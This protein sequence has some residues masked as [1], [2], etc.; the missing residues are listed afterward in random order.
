MVLQSSEAGDEST[1]AAAADEEDREAETASSECES[2]L[3]STSST[4]VAVPASEQS[5]VCGSP[6]I[7]AENGSVS[8]EM[9]LPVKALVK[10]GKKSLKED[11]TLRYPAITG[12]LSE[13]C[14]QS[15]Q[16]IVQVFC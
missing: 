15:I 3:P 14:V 13:R 2:V 6:G 7:S 4:D 10:R 16:H 5:L 8:G 9:C 12:T 1:A 11:Q